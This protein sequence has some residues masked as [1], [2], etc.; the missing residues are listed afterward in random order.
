[1]ICIR[2]NGDVIKEFSESV[3]RYEVPPA[4]ALFEKDARWRKKEGGEERGIFLARIR[5]RIRNI[6]FSLYYI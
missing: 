4:I 6:Y 5:I 2:T 3:W 1:M